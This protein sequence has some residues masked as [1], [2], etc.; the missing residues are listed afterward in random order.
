MSAT[1]SF[2]PGWLHPILDDS[3]ARAELQKLVDNL[4]TEE[5]RM[6]TH[7]LANLI[8]SRAKPSDRS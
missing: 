2:K 5:V 6:T 8:L 1:Y 3:A 4:D 7:Y